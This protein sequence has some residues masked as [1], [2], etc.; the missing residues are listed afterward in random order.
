[1]NGLEI[2]SI[3]SKAMQYRQCIHTRIYML[4]TLVELITH[5]HH[6]ILLWRP[7]TSAQ[8]RLTTQITIHKNEKVSGHN[9]R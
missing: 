7:S 6:Q 2:K 9:Q 5:H 1:M 4:N 3:S 8:E